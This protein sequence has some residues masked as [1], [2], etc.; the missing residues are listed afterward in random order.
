MSRLL[1]Y[2][3]LLDQD[4]T[5]REA[6]AQDPVAAMTAYGLTEEEQQAVLSGDKTR[7]AQLAGVAEGELPKTQVSNSTNDTY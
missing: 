1:D 3:N 7:I 4:A 6:F 2:L 5:A